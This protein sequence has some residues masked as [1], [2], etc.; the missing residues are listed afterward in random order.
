MCFSIVNVSDRL[1]IYKVL[2][3]TAAMTQVRLQSDTII[4]TPMIAASKL[5]QI[6]R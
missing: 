3:S 4:L 1:K 2:D 5:H 6:W